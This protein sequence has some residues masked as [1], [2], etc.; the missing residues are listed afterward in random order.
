MEAGDVLI[1]DSILGCVAGRGG[2]ESETHSFWVSIE[3]TVASGGTELG[4]SDS[5]LPSFSFSS[6]TTRCLTEGSFKLDVLLALIT[7]HSVCSNR[8]I[9]SIFSCFALISSRSRLAAFR[10][11]TLKK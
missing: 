7:E 2:V 11:Y 4:H 6:T 3:D 8:F 1:V 9:S 10:T 5:S